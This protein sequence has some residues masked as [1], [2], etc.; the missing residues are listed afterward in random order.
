[1]RRSLK[2]F[3]FG[4]AVPG[5]LSPVIYAVMSSEDG[6]DRERHRVRVETAVVV[7]VVTDALADVRVEVGHVAS[8][9]GCAVGEERTLTVDAGIGDLLNVDAGSGELSV[10]GVEG[11][12]SVRVTAT[13]CAADDGLFR[14]LD[15]SLRRSGSQVELDTDYPSSG[16]W[17]DGYA[18]IDLVVEVPR[19]MAADIDDSS[20]S[21]EITGVGALTIDDSS[22]DIEVVGASGPVRIDDSSGGIRIQDVSG[23]VDI[24]DGSGEIDV[25]DVRGSVVLSDGSGSIDVGDVTGE[26][27]IRED[28]SGS[29]GV[30]GVGGDFV[31]ERDGSGGIR[32][33]RVN[34][35]VDIPD[36][37]R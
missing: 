16:G 14:G 20:G 4:V 11:L 10:E 29:I 24:E 5:A 30:V 32:H 19:G 37:K 12:E 3:L 28:G 33:S 2:L 1:M 13:L 22:G 9:S 18:R 35:R 31:V 34:G 26:V 25:R 6:P 15:V 7:D 21:M 23:D 36:G 17:S 8:A 27:R